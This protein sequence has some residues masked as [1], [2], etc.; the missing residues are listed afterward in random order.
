MI[1]RGMYSHWPRAENYR[2]L[3]TEVSTRDVGPYTIENFNGFV[4]VYRSAWRGKDGYP[5]DRNVR[6]V[7]WSSNPNRLPS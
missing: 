5:D 3:S 2:G 7:R 6:E 1:T 4:T